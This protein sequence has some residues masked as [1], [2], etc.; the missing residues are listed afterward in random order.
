M[1]LYVHSRHEL[2]LHHQP[3]NQ[4]SL[5]LHPFGRGETGV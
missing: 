1:V 2:P 3:V 5:L 4:K